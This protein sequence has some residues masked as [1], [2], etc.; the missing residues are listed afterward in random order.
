MGMAYSLSFEM[1]TSQ[2]VVVLI[3][4]HHLET[5]ELIWDLLD[6]LCLA[7]LDDLDAFRIP[8]HC[9]LAL[10]EGDDETREGGKLTT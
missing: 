6:L 9:Q 7:G 4:V 5:V 1:G 2:A 8:S 10:E 3:E